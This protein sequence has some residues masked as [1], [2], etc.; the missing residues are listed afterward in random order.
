ML[1]ESETIP[2]SVKF[3]G[4]NS[5]QYFLVQ[6]NNPTQPITKEWISMWGIKTIGG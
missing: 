2:Y 6:I 3:L 4:A 1:D 5:T